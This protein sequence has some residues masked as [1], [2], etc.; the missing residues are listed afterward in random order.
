MERKIKIREKVNWFSK[1]L[2]KSIEK[3]KILCVLGVNVLFLLL[4]YGADIPYNETNDDTGMAA[5]AS[6]AYGE[7]YSEYLVFQNI[8]WGKFLKIFYTLSADIN[9]Y[10]VWQ[11]LLTVISLC[12]L[13]DLLLGKVGGVRALLVYI[14]LLK[15]F[16]QEF[17]LIYQFTRVS[18]LCC[19]AGYLLVFYSFTNNKFPTHAIMGML[20][21]FTG[22]L[23]RSAGF[24]EVTIFAF[25]IGVC[26]ILLNKKF[27]PIKENKKVWLQGIATFIIAAGLI[28]GADQYNQTVISQSTEW[29]RYWE[30]NRMRAILQDYGWPDYWLDYAEYQEGYEAIG[31]SRNDYEM[32]KAGNL[33]DTDVL[34]ME[35]VRRLYEMKSKQMEENMPG[36][37]DYLKYIFSDVI[38]SQTFFINLMIFVLYFVMYKRSCYDFLMLGNM[39]AY[40]LCYAYMYYSNRVVER[41][42]VPT[43]FVLLS[44]SLFCLDRV[45]RRSA[46]EYRDIKGGLAW[47]LLF[48]LLLPGT[49]HHYADLKENRLNAVE[50]YEA[51]DDKSRIFVA[52]HDVFRWNYY[53]FS[54]YKNIPKD[55]YTNQIN[56]GGWLTRTPILEAIKQKNGIENSFEALL[57]EDNIY[58]YTSNSEDMVATYLEEHY[59][60]E[61]VGYSICKVTPVCRFVRYSENFSEKRRGTGGEAR[62]ICAE[63][64]GALEGYVNI[65]IKF[66]ISEN[67]RLLH[68][69]TKFYLE[70]ENRESGECYTYYFCDNLENWSLQTKNEITFTV[71]EG[72]AFSNLDSLRDKCELR[73]IIQQGDKAYIFQLE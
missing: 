8:I 19:L 43:D 18:M 73:G 55:F 67:S 14:I 57:Q 25:P 32:Y 26:A 60:S 17:Y 50:L 37:F 72:Q 29:E 11:L 68:K 30:Y 20:L 59:S 9:W 4:A 70:M 58:Y 66:L 36:I 42:M 65:K 51:L 22:F 15:L 53:F 35:T 46:E 33:S 6:G 52:G 27:Y 45:N 64:S 2:E 38:V 71:P 34:D 49:S 61:N 24:K 47:I 1:F 63:E 39:A 21:V 7:D 3:Y 12:V 62:F 10:S 54:A 28:L 23:I 16:Y 69:D 40:L 48:L 56:M 41:V 13:G 31:I 44:V 5:I